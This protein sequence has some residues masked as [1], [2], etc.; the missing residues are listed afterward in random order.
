MKTTVTEHDFIKAFDTYHRST[1]FSIQGRRAL[2]DYLIEL[3]DGTGE[4]M[5]LDVIALCCD[6]A[7]YE[8]LQDCAA[9]VGFD[10][11]I[12]LSGMDDD[13][14]MNW[15]CREYLHDHTTL[16]EFEGGIIIQSFWWR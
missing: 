13:E 15:A 2:F 9:E 16:I 7:E 14:E 3:E 8:S 6:F 12:Q 11:D 10:S 1:N 4:E 5:E